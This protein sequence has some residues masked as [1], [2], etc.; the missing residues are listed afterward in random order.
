MKAEVYKSVAGKL[1]QELIQEW[2]SKLVAQEE[3]ELVIGENDSLYE[4][5]GVSLEKIE[6]QKKVVKRTTHRESY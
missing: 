2:E 6:S 5:L 1:A 3:L 4:D